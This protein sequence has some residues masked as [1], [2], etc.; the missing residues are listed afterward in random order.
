LCNPLIFP[1]QRT[2]N[3]NR[4]TSSSQPTPWIRDAGQNI[5]PRSKPAAALDM[6]E[7]STSSSPTSQHHHDSGGKSTPVRTPSRSDSSDHERKLSDERL[8]PRRDEGDVDISEG[9][10]DR[11]EDED[12]EA[13]VLEEDPA[14]MASW[15]GQSSVRGGSEMMR[16]ILLSFTS[17]GITYVDARN[18]LRLRQEKP[19]DFELQFYMGN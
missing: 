11:E 4:P 7:T 16:M 2:Q 6:I 10:K 12:D 17:I 15:A 14:G 5:F 1:L 9:D 3:R 8:S 13:L 19:A 18:V